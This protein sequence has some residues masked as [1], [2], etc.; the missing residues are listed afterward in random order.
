MCIDGDMLIYLLCN[1]ANV[2]MSQN[3][4]Q[5]LFVYGCH[6]QEAREMVKEADVSKD[7]KVDYNGKFA[8][9]IY[10]SYIY[11]LFTN[12]FLYLIVY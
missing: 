3:I 10:A 11:F 1:T 9:H 7:G 8:L 2:S 5:Y 12:N 6:Q 4:Q